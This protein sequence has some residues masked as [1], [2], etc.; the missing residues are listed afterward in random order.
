MVL[1]K[2]TMMFYWLTN[3]CKKRKE[4]RQFSSCKIIIIGI[5]GIVILITMGY[6]I[7][8]AAPYLGPCLGC[9]WAATLPSTGAES[10][11]TTGS[12]GNLKFYS[13]FHENGSWTL[14]IN[15]IYLSLITQWHR[16]LREASS[17]NTRYIILHQQEVKNFVRF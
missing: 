2:R 5:Y 12:T 6:G 11:R 16:Y 15:T 1:W 7:F 3:H 10:I 4:E 9:T 13:W 8:S 14:L 17:G